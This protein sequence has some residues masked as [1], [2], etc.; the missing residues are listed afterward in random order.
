MNYF[1]INCL[2]LVLVLDKTFS[3]LKNYLTNRYNSVIINFKTKKLKVKFLVPQGSV[4]GPI[5]FLPFINNIVIIKSDLTVFFWRRY[6]F[7]PM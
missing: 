3:F 6:C 1:C 4:L 2:I 7:W 5:L